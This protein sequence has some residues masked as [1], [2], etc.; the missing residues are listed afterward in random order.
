MAKLSNKEREQILGAL[1]N[2]IDEIYE[3]N[4]VEEGDLTASEFNALTKGASKL[5]EIFATLYE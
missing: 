2:R 3:N 5:V 1:R 4:L